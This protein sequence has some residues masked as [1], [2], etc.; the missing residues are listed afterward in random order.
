MRKALWIGAVLVVLL[1]AAAVAVIFV[2]F[3][4]PQL[5]QRLLAEVS[6]QAGVQ[7]Q[8]EGFHL[9]L[10]RG[11]RLENV[12][13]ETASPAGR[14]TVTAA[15]LVAEH[16]LA[17]LL[18]GKVEIDRVVLYAP[19]IELVTP[20]ESGAP[21]VPLPVEAG[22]ALAETSAAAVPEEAGGGVDLRVDRIHLKDGVLITRTEGLP[23]PDVEIRGLEVELQGL[24]MDPAA[25]TPL[26]GLHAAGDLRMAEVLLGTLR[27]VEGQ[28]R[29]ALDGG[30]FLLKDYLLRLNE[31]RF[32]L[33]DFDADLNRD[34]FAY[35]F[36]CRIEPLDTNTV[37][38]AGPNGGF[39]P[40]LLV[41]TAEGTGTETQD[42]AGQGT[43]SIAA[44]KVPGSPL[45]KALELTLGR[46]TLNG[47]AYDAFAVPFRIHRD[48]L[49]FEPFELRTST[50]AVSFAGWADMAGPVDL[51]VAVKAP[52]ELVSLARVP[53]RVLDLVSQN[54]QVTVPLRVSGALESPRVTPDAEA[55]RAIGGHAVG[56]AVRQGAQR[57][58]G[59]AL[60][61]LFNRH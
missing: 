2:D 46:V 24:S 23:A 52:R 43:L 35:R 58:V 51:R 17:P 53:P 29:L 33:S 36:A 60:G 50:L 12:R 3:D 26:Q 32:L 6:R 59:K 39:G 25:K 15:G 5:G 19:R 54:G 41:F 30:H 40:G 10:A 38:A 34:P 1:G 11:L 22:V 49:I 8:A 47:S 18:R 13:F 9:N 61:K 45:F 4:S 31:G 44:G 48:R 37:L 57:V 42:L 16:R 21:P 20:P 27:A 55:L 7:L 14:L 28:G 56:E